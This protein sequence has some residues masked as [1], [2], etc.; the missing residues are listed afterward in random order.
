[1]KRI[2]IFLSLFAFIAIVSLSVSSVLAQTV[3]ARPGYGLIQADYTEYARLFKEGK[4]PN[5]SPSDAGNARWRQLYRDH[6]WAD[7]AAGSEFREPVLAAQTLMGIYL[8]QDVDHKLT[9]QIESIIW[10]KAYISATLAERIALDRIADYWSRATGDETS[11]YYDKTLAERMDAVGEGDDFYS[12]YE[13]QRQALQRR[14]IDQI[15][16]NRMINPVNIS[17]AMRSEVVV[18]QNLFDHGESYRNWVL[19]YYFM[20]EKFDV[21]DEL[22][23]SF[24][25]NWDEARKAAEMRRLID[26]AKEDPILRARVE[27]EVRQAVAVRDQQATS[28]NSSGPGGSSDS[29][30]GYGSGGYGGG[31]GSGGS[32][33]SPSYSDSYSSDGG[34][35]YNMT[36]GPAAPTAEEIAAQALARLQAAAA[37]QALKEAEIQQEVEN[38]LVNTALGIY[39]QRELRES[40]Y[41]YVVGVYRSKDFHLGNLRQIHR[42]FR[43]GAE[44]G[45]PIAQYHLALFLYNLGDIVDPYSDSA[46]IL[47]EANRWMAEAEKSDVSKERVRQLREQLAVEARLQP[48]RAADMQNKITALYKVENEKMEMFNIVLMGVR[49]RISSGTGVGSR[50]QMGGMMG[51]MGGMMGGMGG[52][53]GGMGGGGY[54]GGSYGNTGG[55]GRNSGNNSRNSGTSGSGRGSSNSSGSSY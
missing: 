11:I 52:M 30:S 20:R 54:G 9:Y 55:S 49:E 19:A 7:Y 53:M 32:N 38:Q 51:G 15:A 16:R 1:M 22:A 12:E 17:Q 43:N 42:Y 14:D 34:G 31:P 37:A 46:T 23:D 50:I 28:G 13:L 25:F 44:A 27:A 6:R 39:W 35:S 47:S 3:P 45:D 24:T 40:A 26:E 36:M 8:A 4:E 5:L 18:V 41:K 2:T 48:R 33:Y 21:L 29:S 10:N